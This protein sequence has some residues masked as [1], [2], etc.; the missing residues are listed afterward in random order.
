VIDKQILLLELTK[1]LNEPDR[2]EYSVKSLHDFQQ[3]L[4]R[5]R[6]E[7]RISQVDVARDVG[8]LHDSSHL[9]HFE[10]GNTSLRWDTL[11]DI[12]DYLGYELKLVKKS[13]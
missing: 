10:S 9:S 12:V 6:K 5:L 2:E 7:Q 3:I 8:G 11:M 4:K 1:L 13:D